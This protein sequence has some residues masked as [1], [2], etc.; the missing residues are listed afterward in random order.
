MLKAAA[1]LLAASCA[2]AG[3]APKAAAKARLPAVAGRFYPAEPGEL[4]RLVD[5]QLAAAPAPALEG[6][7]V[8]LVVPHAGLAYSGPIAAAAYRA[9]EKGRWDSVV[10]I[11]TGHHKPLDGAAI[12]PGDYATPEGRF[13]YDAALAKDIAQA[14]PR[15]VFDGSAH[16]KE[17]SIEVQLPFLQRLLAHGATYVPAVVGP[18]EPE[19]VADALDVL[20]GDLVVVSTDLSHYLTQARA[21]ERDRR[22]AAAVVART[23]EEIGWHA[24]CGLFALRG[25]LAW[26]LRHDHRVELVDLRTSGDTFGGQERV[27]GYGAFVLE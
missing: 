13:V 10:V 4:G 17:H 1:L 18:T 14:S 19:Q 7:L 22:T 3:P 6:E 15:V 5:S 16:D 27:V 26:A 24:A 21:R 11:G 2:W 20:A 23:P 8:A 25:V 9:L 12:Y